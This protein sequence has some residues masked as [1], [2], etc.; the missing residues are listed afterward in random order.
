MRKGAILSPFQGAKDEGGPG[1]AGEGEAGMGRALL[2][3]RS[4]QSPGHGGKGLQAGRLQQLSLP[5]TASDNVSQ[6]NIPMPEMPSTCASCLWLK[7]H[8]LHSRVSRAGRED[9]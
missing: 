3:P 6:E 8:L 2:S 9:R 1:K 4:G 7:P 5:I